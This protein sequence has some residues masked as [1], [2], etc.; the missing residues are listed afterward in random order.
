[1][2]I[3]IFIILTSQ[4]LCYLFVIYSVLH[5][6]VIIVTSKLIV[7]LEIVCVETLAGLG[8]VVAAGLPWPLLVFTMHILIY[9]YFL[10]SLPLWN[11]NW[12]ED[13]QLIRSVAN[14]V[15]S[16]LGAQF[17]FEDGGV[18]GSKFAGDILQC[19]PMFL[20]ISQTLLPWWLVVIPLLQYFINS[21]LLNYLNLIWYQPFFG[22]EPWWMLV[23]IDS[24]AVLGVLTGHDEVSLLLTL[25]LIWISIQALI[26]SFRTLRSVILKLLNVSGEAFPLGA[27]FIV[28]LNCFLLLIILHR[29]DELFQF[30]V[31]KRLRIL[32]WWPCSWYG[33]CLARR[34][35]G[36]DSF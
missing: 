9:R 3:S 28:P 27:L 7:E 16:D 30:E 24:P 35:A 29:L 22:H 31:F 21:Q 17:L 14:N 12:I 25:Q 23:L 36:K 4:Y 26:L 19:W 1:M 13:L 32:L 15:R 18:F 33:N 5:R 6:R 34:W 20:I 11:I 8:K 10:Q 2:V